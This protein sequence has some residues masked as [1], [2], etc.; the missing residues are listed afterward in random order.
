MIKMS[1]LKTG[2]KFVLDG[3]PFVVVESTLSMKGRG[4]SFLRTKI[5]NLLTGQVLSKTF[6]PSDILEEAD[7][8]YSP[9]QYLYKDGEN[10]CFM[11]NDTYDQ[12]ELNEETVGDTKNYLIENSVVSMM[13]YNGQ[14]V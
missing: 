14:P 2:V 11:N 6:Q 9:V 5:R 8:I 1:G 4:G 3:N 7:L 10:F 13:I 12:Y